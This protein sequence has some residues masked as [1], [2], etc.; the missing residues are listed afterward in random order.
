MGTGVAGGLGGEEVMGDGAEEDASKR[1]ERGGGEMVVLARVLLS[2]RMG[3][4]AAKVG[5]TAGLGALG[6]G[7]WLS[8]LALS[9]MWSS[10]VRFS[11]AEE[12][13]WRTQRRLVDCELDRTDSSAR[14]KVVLK[15]EVIVSKVNCF[16]RNWYVPC[17]S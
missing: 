1:L 9:A 12:E 15:R 7:F 8:T 10:S 4:G 11:V 16:V 14:A 5:T 3:V 6:A 2:S 17:R 13:R